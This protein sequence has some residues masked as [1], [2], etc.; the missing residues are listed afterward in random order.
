MKIKRPILLID[1][2]DDIRDVFHIWFETEGYRTQSV[3]SGDK[4]LGLLKGGLEPCI[5]LVDMNMPDMSGEE[6]VKKATEGGYTK[7]SPIYIFSAQNFTQPID[8][9]SGWIRK[10]VDLKA[11]L[12]ILNQIDPPCDPSDPA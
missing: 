7:R 4:A 10:P 2:S 6:F 3:E 12:D 8:G 11:V 9:T 1:D 5:I